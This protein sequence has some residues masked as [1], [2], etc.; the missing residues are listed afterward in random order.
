MVDSQIVEYSAR[1]ISE[2]DSLLMDLDLVLVLIIL[3]SSYSV[4]GLVYV[5]LNAFSV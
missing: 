3:I 4:A 5:V 1:G 2:M